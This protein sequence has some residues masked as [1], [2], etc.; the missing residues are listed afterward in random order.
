MSFAVEEL[1]DVAVVM[2]DAQVAGGAGLG[3]SVPGLRRRGE[4][5]RVAV[6]GLAKSPV[7]KAASASVSSIM[8]HPERPGSLPRRYLLRR[9]LAGRP[10]GAQR[11]AC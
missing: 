2:H 5:R 11:P 1:G 3:V 7:Q 8:H 6:L 9:E 4:R 10:A